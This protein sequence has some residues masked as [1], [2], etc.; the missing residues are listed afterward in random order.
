MSLLPFF[1]YNC[2]P[3]KWSTKGTWNLLIAKSNFAL[4]QFEYVHRIWE[5]CDFSTRQVGRSNHNEK[6]NKYTE[7]RISTSVFFETSQGFSFSTLALSSSYFLFI[8]ISSRVGWEWE[9]VEFKRL[10]ARNESTKTQFLCLVKSIKLF[11]Q[12]SRDRWNRLLAS[13][14]PPRNVWP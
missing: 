4:S 8:S 13:L 12:V 7:M 6:C 10:Y 2:I 3:S 9:R 1:Y 11:L 14:T 5:L